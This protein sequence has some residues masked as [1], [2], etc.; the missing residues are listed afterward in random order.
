MLN[1]KKHFIIMIDVPLIDTVD[2]IVLN[3][4]TLNSIAKEELKHV[5]SG[6]S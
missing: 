2:G 1:D 4:I 5:T 6:D 3:D